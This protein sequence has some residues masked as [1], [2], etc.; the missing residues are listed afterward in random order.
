MANPLS[1]SL[2]QRR[3]Q[4]ADLDPKTFDNLGRRD[5]WVSVE[6]D[7]DNVISE[8]LRKRDQQSVILPDTPKLARSNVTYSY[9]RPHRG[10][11]TSL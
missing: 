2:A 5:V 6:R 7:S 4:R 9:S 3:I 8:L 10:F 1:A 11:L